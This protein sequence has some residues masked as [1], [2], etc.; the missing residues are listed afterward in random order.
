M[1]KKSML[2]DFKVQRYTKSMSYI[3]LKDDDEVIHVTISNSNEVFVATKSGYGLWYDASEIPVVGVKAAGV[4]SINLKND[5]VVSACLFDGD[6]EYVTVFTEKGL[7][8]R[9][10]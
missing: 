5:E 9:V 4:K 6:S 3:K 8:K 2:E 10:K 1:T 7:A